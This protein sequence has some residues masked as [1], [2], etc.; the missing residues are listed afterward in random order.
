MV[1][2][3]NAPQK[4]GKK[5]QVELQE[6]FQYWLAYMDD[7]IGQFIATLP[8]EVAKEMDLSPASLLVLEAWLLSRYENIE[9]LKKETEKSL[10]NGATCY[11]G[12]VFRKNLGGKWFVDWS[13]PKL[14]FYGRPQLCGMRGQIVAESPMTLVSASLDRRTGK[15][16]K[17]VFDNLANR[18]SD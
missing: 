12:E 16:I 7:F 17:G 9:S 18:T 2:K 8:A 14:A 1:P 10:W 15:Y 6:Q 11:V 13:N 5:K 3:T 4:Y